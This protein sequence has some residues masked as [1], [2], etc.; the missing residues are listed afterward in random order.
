MAS[1]TSAASGSCTRI[2][3]TF[4]LTLGRL[5]LS[6]YPTEI[7]QEWNHEMVWH[8]FLGRVQGSSNE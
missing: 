4:K 3:F 7:V 6:E 8:T 1:R 2:F 5:A